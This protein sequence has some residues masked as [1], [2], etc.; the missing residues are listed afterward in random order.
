MSLNNKDKKFLINLKTTDKINNKE[1]VPKLNVKD[2]TS[3]NLNN[4]NSPISKS[5][6]NNNLKRNAITSNNYKSSKLFN[7][8]FIFLNYKL[9]IVLDS[10]FLVPGDII[11]ISCGDVLSCDCL[12]L[13]G[14]CTVN[15]A[16]LT[17]ESSLITKSFLPKDEK[18]FSYIDNKKSFLYHG[19]KI[20]KCEST[21]KDEKL[22]ALVVNTNFNTN[23]GNLIQNILFPRKYDK[24]F[25]KDIII[26]VV[27]MSIIYIVTIVLFINFY[28]SNKKLIIDNLKDENEVEYYIITP[29]KLIYSVTFDEYLNFQDNSKI[30]YDIN[31]NKDS[32]KESINQYSFDAS[33]YN[34]KIYKENNQIKKFNSDPNNYYYYENQDT[35][36]SLIKYI[37][38][39]LIIIMPPILPI[40]NTFTSFY[41]H[42]N[43]NKINIK[44]VDDSKIA[45]SGRINTIVLDK[46]GTLTEE[47]LDLHGYQPILIKYYK[48]ELNNLSQDLSQSNCDNKEDYNESLYLDDIATDSK[49]YYMILEEYYKKYIDALK[50]NSEDNV[51]DYNLNSKFNLITFLECLACCHSIDILKDNFFG[52][53]IDKKIFE[54]LNW[55]QLK[56]DIINN[57]LLIKNITEKHETQDIKLDKADNLK[58]SILNKLNN[59]YNL[60]YNDS[61][62]IIDKFK[63][64]GI[65]YDVYPEGYYKITNESLL[66]KKNH[67]SYDEENSKK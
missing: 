44:C 1:K 49:V 45:I 62:V 43:L 35:S 14:I 48:S 51:K 5:S 36:V 18:E 39:S 56:S 34:N 11:E 8:I 53:S 17:G 50:T 16:D 65:Q 3:K 20:A 31:V 7:I 47:G 37:L 54:N 22:L 57:A 63:S 25:N 10:S 19:T 6:S 32:A 41:F 59:Y 24:K 9:I 2:I 42:Y 58:N 12:I 23:R 28:P 52:N 66:K 29:K 64:E 27:F 60:D 13:E 4:H 30:N 38:L 55:I 21:Y 46:T 26:Y 40:C 33:I 67:L 61:K 15:E